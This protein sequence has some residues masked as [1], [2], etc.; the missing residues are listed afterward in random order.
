MKRANQNCQLSDFATN[1]KL[2]RTTTILRIILYCRLPVVMH[3]E[4]SRDL[5][6]AMFQTR[7]KKIARQLI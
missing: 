6:S 5:V 3:K 7:T 1:I 2:P 4:Y